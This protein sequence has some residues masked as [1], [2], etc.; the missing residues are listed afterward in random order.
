M[1]KD[2]HPQAVKEATASVLPV[3]LE[4]FKVLLNM[5]PR[6][7]VQGTNWDNIAV[8]IQIFKALDTIH[9]SFARAIKPYLPD[10]LTAALNHLNSLYETFD[11]YY[12]SSSET[13]P[14]SSEDDPV[15]FLQL[16]TSTLDFISAVARGGKAREWFTSERSTALVSSVFNYIQMTDED[17]CLFSHHLC[18]YHSLIPYTHIRKWNGQMTQMLL[19]LKMTMKLLLTV[20]V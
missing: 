20:S 13:V 16:I 15:E 10:L 2:Q 19:L 14:T 3:W 8:R 5:E 9:T 11:R 17:V 18:S 12:L 7:D 1:V 6:Q 4:A